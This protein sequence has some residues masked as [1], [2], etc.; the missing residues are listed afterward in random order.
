MH[1]ILRV[2]RLHQHACMQ[3]A[4]ACM[5]A[6]C[7]DMHVCRLHVHKRRVSNC[8][9]VPVPVPLR[10][11]GTGT[12]HVCIYLCAAHVDTY[13]CCT[14]VPVPVPVYLG[15]GTQVDTQTVIDVDADAQLSRHVTR[16]YE[17]IYAYMS[18][19]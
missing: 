11:T 19:M 15:T 12:A 3:S 18:Q 8:V 7:I 13:M 1:K 10:Y 16:W 2:C 4:S 14:H 6:D 5:Y 17:Y 9:P